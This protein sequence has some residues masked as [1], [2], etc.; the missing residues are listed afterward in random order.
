M[1]R[2]LE[3]MKANSGI[4]AKS[5]FR[6]NSGFKAYS[7]IIGF[8][9]TIVVLA[10]V[11]HYPIQIVDALTSEPVTDFGINIS[12]WR[13]IFEPVLG[14]LLFYLR[15]DQPLLEY[16]VLLFWIIA[17]TL[18]IR[19]SRIILKID[20]RRAKHIPGELLSWLKRTPLI[21]CIWLGILWFIIFMW[22]PANTIINHRENT[23]LINMHSHTEYSHDGIISTKGLQKWHG[24]NGFDA[25]FITDHNHHQ[26]TLEAVKAQEDGTLPQKPLIICG[27]EYSGSNHMTLLGLS[28]NFDTGG[29]N[30]QQ[31]I[32][33]T[34][35]E[36]GI[37]IVA[38]WFDGERK[39]IPFFMEIGVDGFEIANQAT[40]LNYDRS[41]FQNIV[42]ACTTNGLLMNGAADYHG[43]GSPC[44][45]WNAMEIP[46]WHHMDMDQKRESVMDLLLR[47]DM[48]KIKI[49]LYR[50]R[51]VFNRS[52]VSL[53]PVYT[54]LSYFRTLNILQLLSWLIWI[55]LIGMIRTKLA[56]M[57]RNSGSLVLLGSFSLAGSL[58][59]L[60]QGSV[61]RIKARNLMEFNDIYY[62]YS[63]IMLLCGTGFLLYAS[64]FMVFEL[65]RNRSN[66]TQ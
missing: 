58:Y 57:K 5:R 27:E 28:S 19:L 54:V 23:I 31:V 18:I 34:H 51:H 22:L 25:F 59:L 3:R 12:I 37:V 10:T 4:K 66:K 36:N 20:N 45:V 56:G 40:G 49:L 35:K 13:I 6:A 21:V 26:K 44:F 2:T 11:F 48:D 32:D 8:F 16:T 63:T 64:I 55:V 60:V 38:H 62:E 24:K 9:A 30:D 53:S 61:I 7:G 50:D 65:R 39:S 33:A 14:P 15:A 47:K 17:L 1:R 29:Q 46:G 42:N 43:Y 52:Y 41:I